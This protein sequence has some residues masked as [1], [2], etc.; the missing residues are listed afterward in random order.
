MLLWLSSQDYAV[1]TVPVLEGLHLKSFCSMGGPGLIVIGSS[2]PA[3]KT[4]KV[5]LCL[6]VLFVQFQKIIQMHFSPLAVVMETA[7]WMQNCDAHWRSCF[8]FLFPL[9]TCCSPMPVFWKV[10]S[11][12][13]TSQGDLVQVESTCQPNPCSFLLPSANLQGLLLALA[14]LP[15]QLNTLSSLVFWK[16]VASIKPRCHPP[17]QVA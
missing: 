9:Y 14:L 1:S 12:T 8:C 11:E 4:L 13:S 5:C 2:E 16:A 17:P 3:Q 15:P 10:F 6:C 7:D